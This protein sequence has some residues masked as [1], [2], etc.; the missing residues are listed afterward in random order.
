[1]NVAT[2][3]ANDLSSKD[4]PS[5][6][7]KH[8]C[9]APARA[10]FAR[11]WSSTFVLPSP[12]LLGLPA[13]GLSACLQITAA[14]EPASMMSFAYASC[15]TLTAASLSAFLCAFFSGGPVP[16][17]GAEHGAAMA[18]RGSARSM[19]AASMFSKCSCFTKYLLS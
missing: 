2:K 9:C 16:Y 6:T 8:A 12:I 15:A 1:M 7:A 14:A 11:S 5:A 17:R 13:R 4:E 3:D 19:S 18:R 10:R